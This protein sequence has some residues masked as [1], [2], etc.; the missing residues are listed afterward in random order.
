MQIKNEID[1]RELYIFCSHG[2]CRNWG[3]GFTEKNQEKKTTL[4]SDTLGFMRSGLQSEKQGE[5]ILTI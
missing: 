5:R 2:Y 1:A 3:N 4:K